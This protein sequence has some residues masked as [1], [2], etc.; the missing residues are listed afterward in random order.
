MTSTAILHP[1]NQEKENA[2][3]V[4]FFA[5]ALL[6]QNDAQTPAVPA[7]GEALSW[8]LMILLFFVIMWFFMIRPQQSQQKKFDQL[9]NDLKVGDKVVTIGGIKA[10]V[11]NIIRGSNNDTLEIQ[12]LLDD[13]NNVKV[14]FDPRAIAY[15]VTPEENKKK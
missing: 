12:L 9:L 10:S 2:M 13:K 3:K 6:A 5:Y 7:G 4:N 11:S 15:V 1:V 8:I 14:M